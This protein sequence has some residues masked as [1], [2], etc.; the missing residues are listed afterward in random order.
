[1]LSKK[2][3]GALGAGIF[4]LAAATSAQ[5]ATITVNDPGNSGSGTLRDAIN[6][7]NNRPNTD[8]IEFRMGA[9]VHTITPTTELPAITEPVTL[10]GYA[11]PATP[12]T[13]NSPADLKVVIDAVNV[14]DGL[15]I[16]ADGVTVQGLNIQHARKEGVHLEGSGN[17][18]AG[19][20]IGTGIDGSATESNGLEGVR[21]FGD[22]N[23]IGGPDSADRNVISASGFAEVL[24]DEG[25]GNTVQNNYVGT[26]ATGTRAL[27]D[28]TGVDL[29]SGSN[30]VRGNLISGEGS[31]VEI[32]SD[33]NVVQ[34][35][36]VGTDANGSAALANSVGVEIFGGDGNMIG[37]TAD[38]EG[39][40]LSG[41]EH[42]GVLLSPL[43]LDPAEHNDV[44]GNLIGTTATGDAPLPNGGGSGVLGTR[45]GVAVS[46]SDNN[47]IGGTATGAGNVISANAGAG[48]EL[49]DAAGNEIL[50]NSIG[51]DTTRALDLGNDGAGVDI[52]GD[53]NRVGDTGPSAANT[54]AHNGQDGVTVESGSGNAVLRNSIHDNSGLAIDNGANGA[55]ANDD[56]QH[57][58]DTGANDLQ[59][60]PVIDSATA[61]DVTWTL[62]SEP[63][64]KYRLEFYANDACTAASVTEARTYLGSTVITTD[65][66]GHQ[67]D[68]TPITL[69]AGAGSHLSVT[70]TK[71]ERVLT[72]IFPATFTLVPRSTS[73]VSPCETI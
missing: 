72:G 12:A 63:K 14:D 73:E 22:D 21:V 58:A 50:G 1:M 37:G 34:G 26:D 38:G 28:H 23:L 43:G 6:S 20:Y 3:T 57:D 48:V 59:N 60:G 71:L 64:T 44:K 46:G 52:D 42:S 16:N 29:L 45:A 66:N 70:A 4:A 56:A 62:E 8:V 68:T 32:S 13:A 24:V 19:N 67:D 39:N 5:A 15:V 9:G 61:T 53:N 51:T 47:T 30:T 31:G 11:G 69:P 17:T 55:T 27:G 49:V 35:N 65:A 18:V 40:V 36:K 33:D 54:I 10:D 25:A 2:L 7:A 41:N